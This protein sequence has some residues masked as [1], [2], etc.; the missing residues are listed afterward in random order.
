MRWMALV[1]VC[2]SACGLEDTSDDG[3][4][5]GEDVGGTSRVAVHLPVPAGK[6][7]V[8]TQ[9]AGGSFSHAGRSTAHDLDFDTSNTRDEDLFAPA[10]GWVRVHASKP[11]VNFGIHVNIDLGDGTYVVL[12]HLKRVTVADGAYVNAGQLIGQE[13][14]TGLCTGD[15]VHVGRHTGDAAKPAEF[16]VSVPVA[17][18]VQTADGGHAVVQG[19]TVRC[20]VPGGAALRSALPVIPD[21]PEDEIHPDPQPDPQTPEEP[22]VPLPSSRTLSFRWD[23]P[24]GVRPG[25]I[26]LSG[27]YHLADGT[28][29]LWWQPLVDARGGSYVLWSLP[30][31]RSGDTFR[32]S[33]EFE[34]ENGSVSWSCLGPFPERPTVQGTTTLAVD[35]VPVPVV[36]VGDPTSSGCGLLAVIP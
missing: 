19:D 15:H 17:F 14:C 10:S 28:A 20:G 6:M 4:V 36:P 32:F 31:V 35:G 34:R 24:S 18:I 26:T 23:A 2:V 27:E 7:L 3:S 8:C 11:G 29:R 25:R 33:V 16:G 30:Q 22:E 1:F 21:L 13:G 12:G 5:H 9:G